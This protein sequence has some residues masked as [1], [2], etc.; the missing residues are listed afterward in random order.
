MVNRRW[1]RPVETTVTSRERGTRTNIR[2]DETKA[3]LTLPI[4]YHLQSSYFILRYQCNNL[5]VYQVN[6][7]HMLPD[8]NSFNLDSSYV[9]R[10]R[11]YPTRWIL[12][13]GLSLTWLA[14]PSL[15]LD[16]YGGCLGVEE[17]PKAWL[18]RWKQEQNRGYIGTLWTFSSHSN[19]VT[20]RGRIH[21]QR[22]RRR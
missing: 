2:L 5:A 16:G 3:L 7:C 21:I 6:L 9:T 8:A 4:S 13:W 11:P 18:E 19:T 1:D 10:L 22:V 15:R 17:Q 14:P 12:A 20:P